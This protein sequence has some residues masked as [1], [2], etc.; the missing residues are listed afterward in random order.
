MQTRAQGIRRHCA[1][2]IEISEATLDQCVQL[3][4]VADKFAQRCV[5]YRIDGAARTLGKLAQLDLDV[6]FEDHVFG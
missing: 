5:G 1:P 3:M 4:L 2:C 6:I